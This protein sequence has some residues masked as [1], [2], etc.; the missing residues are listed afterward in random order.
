MTHE[1]SPNDDNDDE[2]SLGFGGEF[3]SLSFD[4]IGECQGCG[5]LGNVNGIQFCEFCMDEFDE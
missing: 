4:A 3:A 5:I 2:Y 1:F